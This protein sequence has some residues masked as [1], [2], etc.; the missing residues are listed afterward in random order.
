MPGRRP[1][2][3]EWICNHGSLGNRSAG[4][5]GGWR[6]ELSGL[7][8]PFPPPR[9]LVHVAVKWAGLRRG[10]LFSSQIRVAKG[11]SVYS[12][13]NLPTNEPAALDSCAAVLL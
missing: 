11:V 6:K 5:E 1:R 12:V 3:L 9:S 2:P 13:V 4:T 7:P 8:Q 10:W